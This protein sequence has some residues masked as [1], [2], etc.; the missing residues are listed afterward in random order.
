[1]KIVEGRAYVVGNPAAAP[2]RHELGI[3]ETHHR[4][5]DSRV[6]RARR[7]AAR[8]ISRA[9]ARSSSTRCVSTSWS[10]RIRSRSNGCGGRSTPAA[11][12]STPTSSRLR[13]RARSRS[14]AGTSSARRSGS[15]STTCWVVQTGF[16]GVL[17]DFEMVHR[18]P[19][20]RA[21]GS[22]PADPCCHPPAASR[23]VAWLTLH[24]STDRK[25]NRITRRGRAQGGW[26]GA[27]RMCG[28][29]LAPLSGQ[30]TAG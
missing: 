29:R 5:G 26:W 15:R 30:S 20:T 8:S 25:S 6:R 9:P 19:Q 12:T 18:R 23:P 21:T 17:G 16:H 1:M 4:P 22:Y 28:K 27:V 10:A 13:R 2:W 11:T 24:T 7:T 3:R 14:P